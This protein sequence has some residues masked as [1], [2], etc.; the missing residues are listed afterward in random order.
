MSYNRC[1]TI[2]INLTV[3]VFLRGNFMVRNFCFFSIFL[4]ISRG[5]IFFKY[6]GLFIDNHL[7]AAHIFGNPLLFRCMKLYLYLYTL[8][9]LGRM[10]AAIRIKSDWPVVAKFPSEGWTIWPQINIAIYWTNNLD[11]DKWAFI[12]GLFYFVPQQITNKTFICCC[13]YL[14]IN[15]KTVILKALGF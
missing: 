6:M 14:W 11:H 2:S 8:L 13:E 9:Y 5:L 3:L 15:T 12:L 1:T 4:W 10:K 7:N